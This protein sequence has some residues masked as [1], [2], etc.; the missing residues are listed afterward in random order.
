MLVVLILRSAFAIRLDA[1]CHGE[2]ADC[3]HSRGERVRFLVFSMA[4]SLLG[5]RA[6]E[7]QKL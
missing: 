3:H 7:I 2:V 4:Q 5:V 1:F 6:E